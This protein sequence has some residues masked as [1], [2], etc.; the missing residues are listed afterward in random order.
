M[1]WCKLSFRQKWLPSKC[2]EKV[3]KRS[4]LVFVKKVRIEG[5]ERQ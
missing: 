3:P 1:E 5:A 4:D 2:I